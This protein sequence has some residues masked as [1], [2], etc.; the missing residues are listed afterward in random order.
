VGIIHLRN[1]AV[2]QRANWVLREILALVATEMPG[3]D[4][5]SN[6]LQEA[7][8]FNALQLHLYEPDL[9][10]RLEKALLRAA[11]AVVERGLPV[12]PSRVLQD[13]VSREQ[14]VNSIRELLKMMLFPLGD[15]A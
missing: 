12:P 9:A 7:D 2:W 4:D 8:A 13:P 3:D 5:A 1:G 15:G 11:R 10:E 6:I 14:F